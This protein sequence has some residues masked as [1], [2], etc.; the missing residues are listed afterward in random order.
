[1]IGS[2]NSTKQVTRYSVLQPA[3]GMCHQN[4]NKSTRNNSPSSE[5]SQEIQHENK[6]VY[7]VYLLL[8]SQSSLLHDLL[9]S[10]CINIGGETSWPLKL[11]TWMCFIQTNTAL[12]H[13][14]M[15]LT[16]KKNP[17]AL[18]CNVCPRLRISQ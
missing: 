6:V 3:L 14:V 13:T 12:S 2:P 10:Q 18:P 17:K 9:Q 5:K 7:M 1:M 4:S 11:L 16:D 8:H 15:S